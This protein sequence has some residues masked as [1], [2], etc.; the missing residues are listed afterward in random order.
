MTQ[1]SLRGRRVFVSGHRGLV[2][3]ACLRRLEKEDCEIILA[4]RDEV[5]LTRQAEVER[6]MALR[7]PEVVIIAAAKV[8]GILANDT[9]PADFIYQNLT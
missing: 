9:Y 3:S 6:F 8:G 2:G 1:F 7:R 5:D 4:S